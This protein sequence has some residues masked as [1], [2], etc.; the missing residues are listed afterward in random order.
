MAY[1][2][3][4][5]IHIIMEQ[6]TYKKVCQ[7]GAGHLNFMWMSRAASKILHIQVSERMG[8]CYRHCNRICFEHA[9][10]LLCAG[11]AVDKQNLSRDACHRVSQAEIQ[12]SHNSNILELPPISAIFCQNAEK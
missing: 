10:T 3:Q 1:H 11:M 6:S 2:P 7:L 4:S 12:K 9:M 8:H 5:T